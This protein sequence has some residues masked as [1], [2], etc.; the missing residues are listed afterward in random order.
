MY[1]YIYACVCV[2]PPLDKGFRPTN[3]LVTFTTV[4]FHSRGTVYPTEV[5]VQRRGFCG[6]T[7]I[8]SGRGTDV[9]AFNTMTPLVH[10]AAVPCFHGS[11]C[12]HPQNRSLSHFQQPRSFAACRRSQGKQPLFKHLQFRGLFA[13]LFHRLPIV[14]TESLNTSVRVCFAQPSHSGAE[15]DPRHRGAAFLHRNS[16]TPTYHFH[17]TFTG[18]HGH[19]HRIN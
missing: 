16:T 8:S 1:I 13:R 14:V 10:P 9:P 12:Y 17:W 15:C 2:C 5:T 6:G 19:P 11:S 7:D 3:P 18:S 4:Q